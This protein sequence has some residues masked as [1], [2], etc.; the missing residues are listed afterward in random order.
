MTPH[1]KSDLLPVQHGF[2]GSKGGVSTGI[3]ASLNA[4]FGSHDD[5]DAVAENRG[6]IRTALNAD[7]IVSLKQIHSDTVIIATNEP[8]ADMEAD[9]LV[10]KVP[11]LAISALS[12]DC[13]PVLLADA[14][15]AVIGACHAGWRGALSGI[16]ESTVATM[17]ELGATP[18]NMTAVLGPCIGPE[19]Y[20]VGDE[21]KA[22][23]C[24]IDEDYARF[25]HKPK[26]KKTH[27][28]LPAFI[29]SRLAVM[30]VR[31]EW[32]GQCTYAQSEDYFSYRRNS[33][34]GITD[35]GRNLS[36]IVLPS[37]MDSENG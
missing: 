29:L 10:T 17:C 6:R 28:D 26:G 24:E 16:V 20:E 1:L 35:Y 37:S 33:H 4:G 8:V 15:A 3:Y 25:F 31:S 19:N 36:A 14:K 32:T 21:F 18:D 30:G 23:F 22:E 27:F 9:G 7:F 12:A 13:G 11:G 2:F 5:K 34:A